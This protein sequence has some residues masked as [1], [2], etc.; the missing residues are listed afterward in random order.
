MTSEIKVKKTNFIK[1]I[2]KKDLE[3]NKVLSILTSITHEP[4][5]YLHIGSAKSVCLNFG[6]EHTYV[7]KC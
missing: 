7:G 1:N 4:N 2:I 6:I 3:T 5:D